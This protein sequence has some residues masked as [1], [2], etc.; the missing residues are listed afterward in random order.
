[1]IIL[2]IRT[3]KPEAEIGLFDESEELASHTWEAHRQLSSTIHTKISGLLES[4]GKSWHDIKGLV[5]YIGPG[6]LRDCE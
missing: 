5:F 1:M 2:T 4:H 3:D 6:S